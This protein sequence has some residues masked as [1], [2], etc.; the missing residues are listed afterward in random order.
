MSS[1]VLSRPGSGAAGLMGTDP[2]PM[3][4]PCLSSTRTL[5]MVFGRHGEGTMP[6]NG[7]WASRRGLTSDNM[8]GRRHPKGHGWELLRAHAVC[9]RN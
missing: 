2:A 6:P 1:L 4:L 7:V 8:H 5:G 9:D 3:L